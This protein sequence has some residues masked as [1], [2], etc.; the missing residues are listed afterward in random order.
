MDFS[1]A[2]TTAERTKSFERVRS[3]YASLLA[4]LIAARVL[5]VPGFLVVCLLAFTLIPFLGQDFFP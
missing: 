5:F 2:S 1:P 4:R 3:A